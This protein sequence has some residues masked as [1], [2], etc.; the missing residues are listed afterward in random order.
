MSAKKTTKRTAAKKPAT[1]KKATTPAT[2]KKPLAGRFVILRLTKR[3]F[4][5]EDLK[6]TPKLLAD[7][8]T[9]TVDACYSKHRRKNVLPRAEDLC[10]RLRTYLAKREQERRGSEDRL[11][12]GKWYR[13]AGEIL[14]RDLA[15]AR[16]AWLKGAKQPAERKRREQSGFLRDVDA[17][18]QV[19]DFHSL[20][21]GFIT[22]LVMA[23]VPPKVAQALAR[24]STIMLTMDRYTHLEMGDLVEAVGGCQKWGAE[25][26][27]N[28]GETGRRTA[29]IE[30]KRSL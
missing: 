12:P 18:G 4:G 30:P 7:P 8:P 23:N 15:S 26:P 27:F 5:K 10:R 3:F 9:V 14:Q 2:T 1:R 19:L 20:R 11:W 16:A 13:Q 6:L 21:H 22:K 17:A 24:H 25:T 28:P 29:S